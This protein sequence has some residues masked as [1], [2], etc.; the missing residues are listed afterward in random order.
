MYTGFNREVLLELPTKL[1][2]PSKEILV[3]RQST[4]Y[5][6]FASFLF[7]RIDKIRQNKTRQTT[8]LYSFYSII[9]L[10]RA[11]KSSN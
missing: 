8:T 9:E 11:N 2:L 7:W 10:Y 1:P 3:F 4:A 6:S 5:Y